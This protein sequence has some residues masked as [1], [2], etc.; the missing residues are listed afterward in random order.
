MNF[1]RGQS[2]MAAR[3]HQM[4]MSPVLVFI[5]VSAGLIALPSG[6]AALML[7]KGSRAH[8]LAGRVFFVSMLIMAALGAYGSIV[9]P[10]MTNLL[11][12]V[13]TFYLVATA[14]MT[15]RRKAGESGLFEIGACAVAFACSIT[16][17]TFAWQV[18]NDGSRVSDGAPP[19]AYYMFASVSVLAA[20]GDFRVVLRRGIAGRQR[21]VRHLWRMCVA[22]FIAAGSLFF[23]QPQVFPKSLR[24]TLVLALPPLIP[25]GAMLFWLV[26]VRVARRYKMI[27]AH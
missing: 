3:R 25:I 6:M 19:F 1:A 4:R 17:L 18:V 2:V 23:G 21:L 11:A 13:V 15:V 12:G 9:N 10:D 27:A 14:W 8:A 7:R 26:R 5:H 16:A 22:L 20:A 24:G